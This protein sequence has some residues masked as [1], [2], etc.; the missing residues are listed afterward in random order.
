MANPASVDVWASFSGVGWVRCLLGMDADRSRQQEADQKRR[1]RLR[2]ICAPVTGVR[3]ILLR[4]K[5]LA[6]P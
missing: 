3:V 2:W 4:T 1:C 6:A 5:F